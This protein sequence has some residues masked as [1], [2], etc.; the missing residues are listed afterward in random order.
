RRDFLY[1]SC[2]TALIRGHELQRR[3]SA[4]LPF[5][6]PA[7]VHLAP[8]GLKVSFLRKRRGREQVGKLQPCLEPFIWLLL[9]GN[10]L[11]RFQPQEVFGSKSSQSIVAVVTHAY[12]LDRKMTSTITLKCN[13]A[14][15]IA[16]AFEACRRCRIKT[17]SPA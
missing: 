6:L 2:A 5:P 7:P 8:N 15:V 13:I 9:F 17:G 11:S 12:L 3:N 16:P 1:V 14:L 10:T 4:N